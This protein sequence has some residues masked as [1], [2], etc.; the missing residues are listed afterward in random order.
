M[1]NFKDLAD[2]NKVAQ[3]AQK[4]Q[5]QQQIHQDEMISLLKEISASLRE[6]KGLLN[7]K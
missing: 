4:V 3:Q 5:Q 7:K 6:I 2:M 1:F